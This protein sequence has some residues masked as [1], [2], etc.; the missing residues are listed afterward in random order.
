MLITVTKGYIQ[1]YHEIFLLKTER[2]A[3]DY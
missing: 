3:W 2:L 1:V